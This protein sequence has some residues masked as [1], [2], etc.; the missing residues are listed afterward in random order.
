MTEVEELGYYYSVSLFTSTVSFL[1]M[2][3]IV[4]FSIPVLRRKAY[5]TFYYLHIVFSSLIFIGTGIQSSTNFYFL[6]PRLFLWMVDRA[7]WLFRGDTGLTK[8]LKALL[9]M[10]AMASTA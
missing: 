7:W 2:V 9:R 10:R 1:L 4:V 3:A 6:L 5:D 8:G